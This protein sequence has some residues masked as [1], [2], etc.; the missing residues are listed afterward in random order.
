M[1]YR[2]KT[3]GLLAVCTLLLPACGGGDLRSSGAAT[4]AISFTD[5][6]TGVALDAPVTTLFSAAITA[7]ADWSSSFTLKKDDAGDNLCTAV[8]YDSATFTATCTH[9]NFDRASSYTVNI[10]G[11]ED[12]ARL[13][14]AAASATFQTSPA[15]TLLRLD[16]TVLNVTDSPIPR[17]ARIKYTLGGAMAEEADRTA[18]EATIA[19]R[20]AAAAAIAGTYAWAANYLSVVFTPSSKLGYKAA[21]TVAITGED[22]QTFTTMTYRDMDGDGYAD[23][24]VGAKGVVGGNGPGAVY[25]F[26]SDGTGG[27]ADCDLSG[28]C[29]A[30]TT[31]NG[32]Q[33]F[34]Q[35]GYSVAV[36]DVNADGYE[37]LIVGANKAPGGVANGAV[38]LFLGSADGVSATPAATYTGAAANDEFGYSVAAGD[39]NGN[40]CAD[41][42]VGAWGVNGSGNNHGATYVF[43]G[44]AELEP[45][46]TSADA[47]TTI[48]GTEAQ[49]QLGWSVST[50]DFNGDEKADLIVGAN[51]APHGGSTGPGQAYV[52]LGDELE[53]DMTSADAAA[54]ITGGAN[55]N[56]LGV[57][58]SAGDFNGD[59]FDDIIVGANQAPYDNF[60]GGPGAGQAYV[61]LSDGVNGIPDCDMREECIPDTTITGVTDLDQL[62]YSVS[63][64]GDVNGNTSDDIIVGAYGVDGRDTNDNGAAYVFLSDGD[65]GIPDCN[66]GDKTPCIADTTTYGAAAEDWLG[67][68][69]ST[70]GDVDGDTF[71]D[72]IVGAY[73]VDGVGTNS[74]AAYI[75]PGSADGTSDTA[76]TTIA[77]A[78]A[79]DELGSVR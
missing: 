42:I 73:G 71:D 65:G 34:D 7:P 1:N 8:A 53:T 60:G 6:A 31:T 68:S 19:V 37:D 9:A 12:T 44:S 16:G 50:G 77:G 30:D 14:I 51:F 26:L 67:F 29:I 10:S 57:S 59:T 18:L 74:G 36:S 24:A 72:V 40:G 54:M 38:Y 25:A 45:I 23:V 28:A 32:L 79:W 11:L 48:I 39:V 46:M 15:V 69:V 56:R 76:A 49:D 17:S 66:M 63:T 5:G 75:F 58:V 3:L 27:I 33:N 43:L 62:G 4:G 64:A 47:D 52:F 61:I 20:D 41:V 2:T 78:A 21:Y 55:N 35:F 13:N 70:A 22:D